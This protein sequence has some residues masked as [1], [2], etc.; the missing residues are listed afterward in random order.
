[1]SGLASLS[2]ALQRLLP[3]PSTSRP[4]LAKTAGEGLFIR[5]RQRQSACFSRHSGTVG[6][7]KLARLLLR[8]LGQIGD[9]ARWRLSCAHGQRDMAPD[10]V[11]PKQKLA[12]AA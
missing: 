4:S 9:F 6:Y 7:D 12:M 1:M 5:S 2:P 3:H 8:A 11:T 10:G